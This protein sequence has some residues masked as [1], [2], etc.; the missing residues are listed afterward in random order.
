MGQHMDVGV[1]FPDVGQEREKYVTKDEFR[2]L[3]QNIPV[4]LSVG[5]VEESD[6][7]VLSKFRVTHFT[8]TESIKHNNVRSAYVMDKFDAGERSIV[9]DAL[10][11][12]ARPGLLYVA[13]IRIR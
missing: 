5:F 10:L 9:Q 4:C 13:L 8:G 11:S 7:E 6:N 2:Y 12:Q 3:Y 1:P